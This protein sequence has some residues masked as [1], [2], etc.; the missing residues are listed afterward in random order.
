MAEI[1]VIIESYGG[2]AARRDLEK[3]FQRALF[4]R[5][6]VELAPSGSLPR[7][8]MKARRWVKLTDEKEG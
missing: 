8:E 3:R 2:E 6:P 1:K 7:Y 4:L 5:I